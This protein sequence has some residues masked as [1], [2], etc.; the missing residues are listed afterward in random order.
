MGHGGP[1]IPKVKNIS[2]FTPNEKDHHFTQED[3]VTSFII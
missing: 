3:I 1:S 2:I